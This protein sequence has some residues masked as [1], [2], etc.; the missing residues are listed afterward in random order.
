MRLRAEAILQKTIE[1]TVFQFLLVRLRDENRY[2]KD[3]IS[4]CI[5][6]PSGAIKRFQQLEVAFETMLI[7]IPSGAIKSQGRLYTQDLNQFLFQFLLV[8]LR[9]V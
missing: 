8:R 3:K 5:S 1:I 6:I 2:G 7:S 9:G 4:I